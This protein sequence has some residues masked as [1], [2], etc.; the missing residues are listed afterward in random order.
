MGI[1]PDYLPKKEGR[2]VRFS[3]KYLC[4]ESQQIADIWCNDNFSVVGNEVYL[5]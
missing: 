1:N 4:L 2:M 3:L 5:V